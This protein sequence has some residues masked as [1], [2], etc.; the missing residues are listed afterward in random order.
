MAGIFRNKGKASMPSRVIDVTN[1]AVPLPFDEL[2]PVKMPLEVEIGS[3]NGR[4][5]NWFRT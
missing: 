4:F 3:G 5:M 2:F 1:P